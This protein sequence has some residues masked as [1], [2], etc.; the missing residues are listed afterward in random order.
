MKGLV[1]GKEIKE[2]GI[3]K[4]N[5][6]IEVSPADIHSYSDYAV[7]VEG[8]GLG[9]NVYVRIVTM[10]DHIILCPISDLNR[11][12]NSMY[13]NI[14]IA[15]ESGYYSDNPVSITNYESG[16]VPRQIVFYSNGLAGDA[17][18]KSI[19]IGSIEIA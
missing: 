10:L 13:F 9:I 12:R 4:F 6:L 2:T 15:T 14:R 7:S 18:F 19:Q 8:L 1:T 16:V 5:S 3:I 17:L 11:S